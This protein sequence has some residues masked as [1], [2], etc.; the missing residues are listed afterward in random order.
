[1]WFINSKYYQA[2]KRRLPSTLY[3][4]MLSIYFKFNSRK[5]K[6]EKLYCPVCELSSA[7]FPSNVCG[8][9]LSGVRH[10]IVTLF[11][12][13][14]TTLFTSKHRFLHFAPEYGLGRVLKKQK[15]ISYLSADFNSPRAMKK[16]DMMKTPFKDNTFDAVL[17]IDV[18]DDIPDDHKA[19]TELYRILKPGGWSIHLAP[20]D[21]NRELTYEDPTITSP[22]E[23]NKHF[24]AYANWRIYGKDYPLR[25]TDK[26]FTHHVFKTKEFCS[27][28]EIEKMKIDPEFEIYLFKKPSGLSVKT[29]LNNVTS[30]L[31][32]QFLNTEPL[33]QLPLMI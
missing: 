32:W 21:K 7:Y 26:G 11:L 14:K 20:L 12:K 6:G 5:F 22:E 27:T 10:R 19:I 28:K 1:M 4:F 9:C 2:F 15:N 17:S 30:F 13:R 8:R 23:R 16:V 25:F 29:R 24:N 31:V 3:N 33:Q 18:L